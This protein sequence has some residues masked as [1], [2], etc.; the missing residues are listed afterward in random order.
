[1]A[2]Q[3]AGTGEISILTGGVDQNQLGIVLDAFLD[4]PRSRPTFPSTRRTKDG[5]MPSEESFR[6]YRYYAFLRNIHD[7]QTKK[8]RIFVFAVFLHQ[9]WQQRNELVRGRIDTI[10][11]AGICIDSCG[12]DQ[13]VHCYATE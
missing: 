10:T 12:H 11:Q 7:P 9:P 5:A 8:D 6:L 2:V 4:D 13:V 1:M 3:Y